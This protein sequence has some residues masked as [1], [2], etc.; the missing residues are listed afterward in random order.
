MM[1]VDHS[2]DES[3]VEKTQWGDVP[4]T[5]I[6][7]V[8]QDRIVDLY[9]Q[10]NV[11]FAPSI[12][13]ESYGLVTREA[14]ACGCWVVASNLGGIG[15]DVIEGDSGFIVKPEVKSLCEVISVID[16]DVSKFKKISKNSNI[17]LVTEQVEELVEYYG[18]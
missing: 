15:E 13:P 9:R 11:L 7:R 17:R 8:Q 4:V 3:Y 18:K 2:K 10:M 14:A 16:L 6:G 5:I 1:L 12:W